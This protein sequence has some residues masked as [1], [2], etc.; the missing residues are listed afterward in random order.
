MQVI[1]AI[2]NQGVCD[3]MLQVY[4]NAQALATLIADN[5]N[6][7]FVVDAALIPGSKWNYDPEN[8]YTNKKALKGLNGIR[9]RTFRIMN[10]SSGGGGLL[11]ESG[12]N[13]LTEDGQTIIP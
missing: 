7:D 6:S 5:V 12:L 11:T 9:I 8:N 1:N 10:E 4:G 3:I 13:I 2:Q